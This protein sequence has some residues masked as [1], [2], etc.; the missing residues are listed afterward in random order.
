MNENIEYKLKKLLVDFEEMEKRIKANKN[1]LEKS[2]QNIKDEITQE[3][4]TISQEITSCKTLVSELEI[5]I[6]QNGE[7]IEQNT[8]QIEQNTQNISQNTQNIAQNTTN[9]AQNT[10]DIA[11]NTQDIANNTSK[12]T[13]NT[14]KIAEISNKITDISAKITQLNAKI[15]QIPGQIEQFSQLVN[16]LKMTDGTSFVYEDFGVNEDFVQSIPNC[17]VRD[18]NYYSQSYYLVC[19]MNQCIEI[20]LELGYDPT[21]QNMYSSYEYTVEILLNGNS[22]MKGQYPMSSQSSTNTQKINILSSGIIF[23]EQRINE[24]RIHCT[25]TTFCIVQYYKLKIKGKNITVCGQVPSL[26]I[27][28][29]DNK[30]FVFNKTNYSIKKLYFSEFEKDN[31]NLDTENYVSVSSTNSYINEKITIYPTYNLTTKQYV[32]FYDG[33]FLFPTLENRNKENAFFLNCHRQTYDKY[34]DYF[35]F[36]YQVEDYDFIFTGKPPCYACFCLV[37]SN[38]EPALLCTPDQETRNYVKLTFN[39]EDL[40]QVYHKCAMVKNNNITAEDSSVPLYGAIFWNKTTQNWEY[41]ETVDN[42]YK[43]IL[44]PGKYCTAYLQM[45]GSIN[46]YISRGCTTY[47]YVLIK[48]AETNEYELSSNISIIPKCTKYDE[49]YDGKGLITFYNSYSIYSQD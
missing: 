46:V 27:T 17:V 38:G 30:Y 12:I 15:M 7:T 31:L 16:S 41:Y 32:N 25:G 19:D 9:I 37:L 20:E 22:I 35:S 8:T 4:Q 18:G 40:P 10:A 44:P 45:D 3:I 42:T 13:Q 1:L 5:S 6:I 11:Q 14:T 23:P 26:T 39:G 33:H 49:L 21:I 29:F 34:Y 28:C 48:N 24:L 43:I 2:S 47:K 36:S